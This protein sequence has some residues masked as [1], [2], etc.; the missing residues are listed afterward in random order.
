MDHTPR[1]GCINS[2]SL[3]A[4]TTLPYQIESYDTHVAK[5]YVCSSPCMAFFLS[6]PE[7]KD[8]S[9]NFNLLFLGVAP[10]HGP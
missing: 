3:Q 10:P 7:E 5:F 9:Q 1:H 6:T 8:V 2:G 4:Y